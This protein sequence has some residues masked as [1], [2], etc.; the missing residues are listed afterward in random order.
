MRKKY[1][2]SKSTISKW[3][4]NFLFST[5]L[6]PFG[7]LFFLIHLTTRPTDVHAYDCI[8]CTLPLYFKGNLKYKIGYCFVLTCVTGMPLFFQSLNKKVTSFL[9][10]GSNKTNEQNTPVLSHTDWPD[11]ISGLLL[12]KKWLLHK[13]GFWPASMKVGFQTL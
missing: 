7:T 4:W 10:L 3:D 6:A 5:W 12:F 13:L 11:A 8:D 1:T 9:L 2:K